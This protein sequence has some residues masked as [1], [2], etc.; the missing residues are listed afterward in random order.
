MCMAVEWRSVWG[1]IRRAV[2]D[3][4]VDDAIFDARA[5]DIPLPGACR[6]LAQHNEQIVIGYLAKLDRSEEKRLAEEGLAG[7]VETWPEY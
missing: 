2:N 1:E 4:Q 7:G 5:L 6:E 3:A